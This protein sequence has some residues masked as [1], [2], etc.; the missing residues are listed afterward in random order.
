MLDK[1]YLKYQIYQKSV[2]GAN[3][4]EAKTVK[5][6][7]SQ[8]LLAWRNSITVSIHIYL[9]CLIFITLIKHQHEASHVTTQKVL[10]I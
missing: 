6:P 5:M 3:A 2:E 1:H 7:G 4:A 9:D 10:S 8:S